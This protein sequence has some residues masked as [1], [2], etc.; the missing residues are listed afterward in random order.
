MMKRYKRSATM[1]FFFCMTEAM[2]LIFGGFSALGMLFMAE[3][4]VLSIIFGVL[5]ACLAM[6]LCYAV[7][8]IVIELIAGIFIKR[9]VIIED[10]C[11]IWNGKKVHCDSI[12]RIVFDIG[13]M[14]RVHQ[15]EAS[16]TLINMQGGITVIERPPYLLLFNIKKICK[17]ATFELE[18]WKKKLLIYPIFAILGGAIVC[19]VVLLNK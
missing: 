19:I 5:I 10:D 4:G 13:E 9:Q 11:I 2:Y 15:R 14:G 17:N 18:N 3:E 6:V 16:I 7:I 1:N 12:N 8:C